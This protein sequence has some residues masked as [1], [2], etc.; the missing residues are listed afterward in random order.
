[1]S[2]ILKISL[3]YPVLG[4]KDDYPDSKFIVTPEIGLSNNLFCIREKLTDVVIDNDYLDQ[5]FRAGKIDTAYKV[6]CTSTLYCKT[7]I[8]QKQIEIPADNLANHVSLEVFLV[9]TEDIDDFR[10]DSFNEDYFIGDPE[11]SF[12]I[13]KGYIVGM[14][15]HMAIPLNY[16]FLEAASSMFS[17]SR[18]SL[19]DPISI[20]TSDKQIEIT[21]P[22]E[23]DDL[24][25]SN[26]L[27]VN[28]KTNTFLNL[29]IIPALNQA[30]NQLCVE[31]ENG[32][33]EEFKNR[34]RWA[35]TLAETYP[36]FTSQ[37][38]YISAQK[39]LMKLLEES[40][41]KVKSPV[42]LSFEELKIK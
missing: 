28:G 39:Y 8:G 29:F 42:L 24:D 38:P 11:R 16:T 1:M 6:L 37:D 9:A 18:G 40:G 15:G 7:F 30:F 33:I 26:Y 25:I 23:E 10:D 32:D 20:D 17:F 36:N 14:A 5:L 22:Y 31:Y 21:Y 35:M 2:N 3:P 13:K 4:L 27:P 34:Y 12:L 41:Q 19:V